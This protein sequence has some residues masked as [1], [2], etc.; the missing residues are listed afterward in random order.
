[1]AVALRPV[2]PTYDEI[3]D[4]KVTLM[5]FNCEEIHQQEASLVVEIF[6]EMCDSVSRG[7][8]WWISAQTT[9]L[10][11]GQFTLIHVLILKLEER[12]S[13][14]MTK[15]DVV[16]WAPRK[17]EVLMA[18][19][20]ED[21]SVLHC[22]EWNDGLQYCL[23][24]K[25]ADK[26]E[27]VR[28]YFWVQL[29]GFKWN[30]S[31]VLGPL[32]HSRVYAIPKRAKKNMLIFNLEAKEIT[33]LEEESPFSQVTLSPPGR[34]V[35]AVLSSKERY[36]LAIIHILDSKGDQLK[37]IQIS[38]PFYPHH[39]LAFSSSWTCGV[40]ALERQAYST[41]C[42][43]NAVD[44]SKDASFLQGLNCFLR[45]F[46]SSSSWR[47]FP[48]CQEDSKKAYFSYNPPVTFRNYYLNEDILTCCLVNI[49][50]LSIDVVQCKM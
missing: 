16:F 19:T 35:V 43:P 18:N 26:A 36:K 13:A 42:P 29:E 48:T 8:P 2:S 23:I 37:R 38:C 15:R 3:I 34:V 20:M 32:S 1:V 11:D 4:K 28:V 45:N 46:F 22:K 49:D 25:L 24:L 14:L 6:T 39:N 47:S 50:N 41:L 10:H 17:T 9:H 5:V 33:N 21:T 12:G 27:D 44:Y 31:I 30:E 40:S 7:G